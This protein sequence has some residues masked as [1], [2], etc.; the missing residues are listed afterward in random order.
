MW[1]GPAA[2]S[3]RKAPSSRRQTLLGNAG[4]QGILAWAATREENLSYFCISYPG[5][6]FFILTFSKTH[7]I[8]HSNCNCPSAHQGEGL[9]PKLCPHSH[10]RLNTLRQL[11]IACLF[12]PSPLLPASNLLMFKNEIANTALLPEPLPLSTYSRICL[13]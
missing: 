12:C 4:L 13:F 11:F 10:S 1:L 5:Q 3:I 6:L 8:P 9:T 7:T 2:S